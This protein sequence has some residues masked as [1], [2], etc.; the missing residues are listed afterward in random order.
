MT[1]QSNTRCPKCNGENTKKR[2]QRQTE[3]RGKIQRHFCKDCR[4]SFIQ[5]D[6]FYRMRNTPQKITL[7]LDLF[8]RGLS[9]REVQNHLQAFYPHNSDHSTILRWIRKYSLK[10]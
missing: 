3:N 6:G 2:G 10:I 8:F 9:T 7:S 4:L 1:T 5:N